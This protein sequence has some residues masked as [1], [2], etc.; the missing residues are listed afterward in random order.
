MELKN[1]TVLVTLLLLVVQAFAPTSGKPTTVSSF[2][3]DIPSSTEAAS[4]VTT[5]NTSAATR[6]YV[7]RTQFGATPQQLETIIDDYNLPRDGRRRDL[8]GGWNYQS[9]YC[10]LSEEQAR[11]LQDDARV[12]YCDLNLRVEDYPSRAHPRALVEESRDPNLW[13][14]APEDTWTQ[15]NLFS[16][17]KDNELSQ[18]FEGILFDKNLGEGSIIYVIDGG[19]N[20]DH[21]EFTTRPGRHRSYVVPNALTEADA[22]QDERDYADWSEDEGYI[23]H[24]TA[25]ASLAGGA[26]VSFAPAAEL[27]VVKIKNGKSVADKQGFYPMDYTTEEAL[28]DAFAFILRDVKRTSKNRKAIVTY[29]SGLEWISNLERVQGEYK[30]PL[31]EI[32]ENFIKTCKKE[33][34]IFVTAAGNSGGK[35]VEGVPGPKKDTLRWVPAEGPKQIGAVASLD[36]TYPQRLGTNTNNVITVG[37]CEPDG[38]LWAKSTPFIKSNGGWGS[39]TTYAQ[40]LDVQAA[41]NRNNDKKEE[42]SGTSM[43]APLVAGLIAYLLSVDTIYSQFSDNNEQFVLDV[44]NFVKNNAWSR[45]PRW[46]CLFGDNLLVNYGADV[47][48]EIPVPINMAWKG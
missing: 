42:R 37:G 27:V 31:Q 36:F 29:Q 25:T 47:P 32:F 11:Q 35:W 7:V 43:S 5:S 14:R 9:Y 2:S 22:P 16:A 3:A 46:D 40:A 13:K 41:S 4:N 19:Y 8:T 33:G 38:Y 26:T 44:K 12:R 1:A 15:L 18:Q 24:G 21:S 10:E 39:I 34:I 30:G 45:C 17:D 48:E 20:K 6:P 23:G 28:E